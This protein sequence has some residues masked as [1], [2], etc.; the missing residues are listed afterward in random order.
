MVIQFHL[1]NACNLRCKHCYQGSYTKDIVSLENFEKILYE[2]KNFFG[3]IQNILI[4][5]GEPFIVPNIIDYLHIASKYCKQIM[6]LTNGTLLTEEILSQALVKTN[7]KLNR[8]QVSLEGPKQ[9][10]DNIRGIGIYDKVREAIRLINNMNIRSIVSCT[11]SGYNY[12]HIIELYDDLIKQD[13]PKVLWFDRCIPFRNMDILT[14]E[15]FEVFIRDLTQL[16]NNYHKN[17]LPTIPATNRALEFFARDDCEKIYHCGAGVKAFTIMHTGDVMLCRRLNTVVGNVLNQGWAT[18]LDQ[19][20]PEIEAVH[21][22]PDEC[23]SCNFKDKCNGG[24]KC[25]TW[26]IY[27]DFNHKDIN[28]YAETI[29]SLC[30]A[31]LGL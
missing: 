24:L 3:I 7:G 29:K 1:T 16:Y 18:I 30:S 6:I 10:N 20:A 26:N 11:I 2:T 23:M 15:Q 21:Q 13:A 9:I 22:C 19:I 25:L 27:K 12:N 31:D 4:T 5:G 8:I 14:L 17:N 28:C